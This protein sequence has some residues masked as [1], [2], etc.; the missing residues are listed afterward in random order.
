LVKVDTLFAI[1]LNNRPSSSSESGIA[2]KNLSDKA[3]TGKVRRQK[4][5]HL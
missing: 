2:E 4:G 5:P 1:A 3:R